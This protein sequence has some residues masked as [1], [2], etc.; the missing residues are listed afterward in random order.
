MRRTLVLPSIP[1]GPKWAPRT[2]TIK[3]YI[4]NNGS[5]YIDLTT[6]DTG[7]YGDLVDITLVGNA[8]DAGNTYPNQRTI[9]WS[10]EHSYS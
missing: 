5:G 7:S 3:A 1:N 2:R 6:E 10:M 4:A 9:I 8:I